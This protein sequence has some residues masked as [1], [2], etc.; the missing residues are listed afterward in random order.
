M[1]QISI[2]ELDTIAALARTSARSWLAVGVGDGA[3][4]YLVLGTFHGCRCRHPNKN[5]S[6]TRLIITQV[7]GE[8]TVRVRKILHKAKTLNHGTEPS[9]DK[10]VNTGK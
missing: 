5:M 2:A 8:T 7:H 6:N 10:R 1:D 3:L 9:G 4:E